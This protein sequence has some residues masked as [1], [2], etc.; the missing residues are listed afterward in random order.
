MKAL[1]VNQPWAWAIVHGGKDIENR[2]WKTSFRGPFWIHAGKRFDDEGL[3]WIGSRFPN[4]PIIIDVLNGMSP[5]EAFNFGGIIGWANLVD[6]VDK[7]DSPWFMGTYGFVLENAEPVDFLPC[8]GM[9]NFF[10]P[11]M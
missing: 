5:E 8:R 11:K 10:E 7:S 1:S 2:N 6:C 9:L 3:V 4:L